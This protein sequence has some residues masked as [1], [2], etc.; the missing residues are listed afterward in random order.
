[1]LSLR[2]KR[3]SL[4]PGQTLHVSLLSVP[5]QLQPL[6]PHRSHPESPLLLAGRSCGWTISR[7]RLHRVRR[8]DRYGSLPKFFFMSFPATILS[9]KF[10]FVVTFSLSRPRRLR[11]QL[12]MLDTHSCDAAIFLHTYITWAADADR[13]LFFSSRNMEA[14]RAAIDAQ[15]S[16]SNGDLGTSQV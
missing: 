7:R 3:A 10:S 2:P 6:R 1:M 9:S 11:T 5:P 16:S 4:L 14:A 8:G 12:G 13:R 15:V